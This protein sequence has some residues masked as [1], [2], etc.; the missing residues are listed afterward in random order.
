MAIPADF[1]DGAGADNDPAAPRVHAEGPFVERPTPKHSSS[2]KVPATADSAAILGALQAVLETGQV[3][4]L[5]A[6]NVPDGRFTKTYSGYFDDHAKLA[7]DAAKLSNRGAEGVYFIPNPVQPELLARATNRVRVVTQGD[8]T[9]DNHI[10]QRSWLL[11]DADPDRPSG[12]SSTDE[13]HQMAI[14]LMA[15]LAAEMHE[16]GW[17]EPILASSGNGAH[18]LYPIDLDTSAE[19]T[20]LVK[21]VL[22]AL[23]QRFDTNAVHLDQKVFNAS[24]IWK[25]YGT[26]ARKGDDTS[27]RPHRVG[28]I[29]HRPLG[30]PGDLL[31]R[32]QLLA[33]AKTVPEAPKPV[34]SAFKGKASKEFDLDTW[35]ADHSLQIDGPADWNGGG[36]RWVFPECPWD[37]SHRRKAFIVQHAN[38]AIAAGCVCASCNGRTWADLREMY[39]PAADRVKPIMK[40]HRKLDGP[41]DDDAGSGDDYTPPTDPQAKQLLQDGADDNGNATAMWRIYGRDFL[42]S[43]AYNWLAWTGTHW[44]MVPEQIVQQKAIKLLLR[45]EIAAT[46]GGKQYEEIARAAVP[47]SAHVASCMK[48]FGSYVIEPSTDAFDGSPDLLNVKN[49]V[50]DLRTGKLTPHDPKTQRFT[51]CVPVDYDLNVDTTEWADFIL[52]ALDGKVDVADYFQNAMGYSLTGHTR[53]EV[54]F[55]IHGPTGAGK[56]T[57]SEVM[58]TLMGHPLAYGVDFNTFTQKRDVDSQNF[59]L[60]ELK[61]ARLVFASESNKYQSLN[62]AKI[63][64]LTG[65]DFV[66]CAFKHQQM[67]SYRPMFKVWLLANPPLKADA[68][69]EALWVRVRV[70]EFPHSHRA[71]P[72][73][74]LKMRMKSLTMLPA[75]LK[76]AVEG[77]RRWYKTGL[78]EPEAVKVATK[79]HRDQQDYV[80]QWI[81]DACRL[82]PDA[83]YPIGWTPSAELYQSYKEWCEAQSVER[84]QAQNDLMNT[85]VTR[86]G[87][88]LKRTPKARGILGII[89]DIN[90]SHPDPDGANHHDTVRHQSRYH[91]APASYEEPAYIADSLDSFSLNDAN[92]TQN[93]VNSTY[94]RGELETLNHASGA[95]LR[96]RASSAAETPSDGRFLPFRHKRE[97]DVQPGVLEFIH[98]DLPLPFILHKLKSGAI[99]CGH[100]GARLEPQAG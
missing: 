99:T 6:L 15:D 14:D 9:G 76:W 81:E 5:R 37:S 45:R 8:S 74:S 40:K 41:D 38:G 34:A 24:R 89:L 100:C 67:F 50:L 59:D 75:V 61:P 78:V 25:L 64:A 29:L 80:R 32:K 65:G 57:V 33:L 54:M 28:K 71:K 93:R 1:A 96:H 48:L 27:E 7:D 11:L 36:K 58:M 91:D 16:Q 43:P 23:A 77:A 51:Y 44:K 98:P 30:I 95:S 2:L 66:R 70:F 72:D 86:F 10:E 53:E 35:I 52:Q 82:V 46:Q 87:C 4:E 90:G 97:C 39:D 31:T 69:D 94:T 21:T 88:E 12:I 47:S 3:T 42:F 85:L 56:G 73:T 62:P 92:D 68:D 19:N 18:A 17:P 63:K 26:V 83:I 22:L 55:Y 13:Q 79:A 49:G 60:A 84:P 20:Q